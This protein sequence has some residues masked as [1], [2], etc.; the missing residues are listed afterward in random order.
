MGEL[1]NRS[2]WQC[3]CWNAVMWVLNWQ[4]GTTCVIKRW[5]DDHFTLTCI[6]FVTNE[7]GGP[8]WNDSCLIL[9][10]KMTFHRANCLTSFSR[11]VLQSGNQPNEIHWQLQYWKREKEECVFMSGF[12][13][14]WRFELLLNHLIFSPADWIC[15]Q[16]S[17]WLCLVMTSLCM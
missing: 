4:P 7:S 11:H 2:F 9:L 8:F 6:I 14:L 5:L 3:N 1:N 13:G 10:W 17:M 15:N 12:N 16:H